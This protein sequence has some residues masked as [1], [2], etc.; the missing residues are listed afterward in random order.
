MNIE[1]NLVFMKLKV[2]INKAG[3]VSIVTNGD[4]DF[5]NQNA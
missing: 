5:Q 2:R 1:N 4:Y 3:N